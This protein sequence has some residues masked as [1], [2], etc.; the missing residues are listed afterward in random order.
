VFPMPIDLIK[1]VL[2]AIQSTQ[3]AV[4]PPAQTPPGNGALGTGEAPALPS[5]PDPVA[6]PG[7][8]QR[9]ESRSD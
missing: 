6:D 2:D 8:A 3:P 7:P 4:A 9:Q 1:P 5:G